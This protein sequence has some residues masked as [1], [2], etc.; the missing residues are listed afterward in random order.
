MLIT[1][2]AIYDIVLYLYSN[3]DGKCAIIFIV[4]GDRLMLGVTVRLYSKK[5]F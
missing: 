2:E 1:I 5:E 4:Y 3:S